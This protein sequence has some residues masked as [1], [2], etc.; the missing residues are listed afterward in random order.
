MKERK[1]VWESVPSALWAASSKTSQPRAQLQALFLE[2][3]KRT[4]ILLTA[5]AGVE[6]RGH[7]LAPDLPSLPTHC[8]S[9]LQ[10]RDAA[11]GSP[12]EISGK[13]LVSC[14]P[15]SAP[16]IWTQR[17]LWRGRALPM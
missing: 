14:L 5:G 11:Y 13:L 10:P 7:K 16:S 8:L 15:A 6:D 17:G 1:V 3:I 4:R 12:W 2:H 9:H